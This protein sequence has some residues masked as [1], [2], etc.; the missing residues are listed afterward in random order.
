MWPSRLPSHRHILSLHGKFPVF[1]L[2][3]TPILS[4]M[5]HVVPD[6]SIDLQVLKEAHA[7]KRRH[8]G[9]GSGNTGGAFGSSQPAF[10]A[11]S[12]SGGGLFGSSTATAGAGTGFGG[13]G[14]NNNNASNNTGSIFG[15]AGT[16]KPAFGSSNTGG[17][18]L[19]GNSNTSGGAFGAS[20]QTSSAFGTPLSN[21]LGT[22][23]DSCPGSGQTPFQAHTEKEPNGNTTNI[24]NNIAAM[25]SYLKYS[26][27][28]SI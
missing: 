9:F 26:P 13:F 18:S 20:N 23:T 15:G 2:N 21:A 12:S 4:I 7:N 3:I 11:T 10:G 6:A 22:T 5:Y 16:S 8:V 14:S 28:V 24:F 27:E 25:P 17:G 19:F 1:F